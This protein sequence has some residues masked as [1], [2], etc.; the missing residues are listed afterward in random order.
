MFILNKN[1]SKKEYYND[2]LYY[3]VSLVSIFLFSF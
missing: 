2:K 1:Y 3:D